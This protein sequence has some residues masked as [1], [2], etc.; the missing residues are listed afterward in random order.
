MMFFFDSED[1]YEVNGRGTCY[2]VP[3]DQLPT[4]IYDPN[5]LTGTVV[6][7]DNRLFKVTGVETFATPRSQRSPY[8]HGFAV[9]GEWLDT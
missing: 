3:G 9:I 1:E 8:R 4:E 2:T 7:L 5:S 6:V